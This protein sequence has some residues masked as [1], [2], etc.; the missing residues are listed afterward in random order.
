[1]NF[2][3][4]L[5]IG[6]LVAMGAVAA[7]ARTFEEVRKEGKIVM[8][9]EGQ[10][11]PYNFFK[12]SVLTGFEIELAE[13]VAKKWGVTI[14]WKALGFDALLAGLRHDRWDLVIAGHA[15]T[16]ERSRSV[17]FTEPHFCGGGM[18]VARDAA[19]NDL[20]DLPGKSVAVQTGTTFLDE[21]KKVPGLKEIKNFPQD[22]DAR[23]A[24]MSGRA[25][26]W[27]TDPAVARAAMVA[28]PSAGLRMVGL[29]FV[30]R[31]AA[32]VAKGNTSL[33][34]AFSQTVREL[35]ADGT[36]ATL[37]KKYFGDDIRCK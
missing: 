28:N 29:L 9:T 23:S 14:D 35:Q 20:K 12:G 32:V 24:L 18:V 31:N 22:T 30:E 5:A 13:A 3:K 2:K 26:A 7:Q 17:T 27:I 33:A 1:M 25:D 36:Y 10:Y 16:P 21:A 6:L 8:A 15:I 37:S 34:N 11:P 4:M 19:I